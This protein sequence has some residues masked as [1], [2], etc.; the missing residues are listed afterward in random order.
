MHK[1]SGG[2][3]IDAKQ[4]VQ[5]LKESFF[6]AAECAVQEAT[7]KLGTED[8]ISARTSSVK[9]KHSRVSE[10]TRSLRSSLHSE[11]R[12]ALAEAAAAKEQAEYNMMLARLE[13][14]RKQREAQV[15]LER[16]ATK[17][18]HE[19]DMAILADKRQ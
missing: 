19:C 16:A 7:R 14:E 4:T 2:E 18:Q 11:R 9:S 15:K 8:N 12:L 6:Q 13:N 17:A 5:K 1:I 3:S 10:Q